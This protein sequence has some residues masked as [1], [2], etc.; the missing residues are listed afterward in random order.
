MAKPHPHKKR[1]KKKRDKTHNETKDSTFPHCPHTKWIHDRQWSAKFVHVICSVGVY[2]FFQRCFLR[3]V[4]GWQLAD[5]HAAKMHR[6]NDTLNRNDGRGASR[7]ALNKRTENSAKSL[8]NL[9]IPT[10]WQSKAVSSI[11]I[12]AKIS[13]LMINVEIFLFWDMWQLHHLVHGLAD[14]NKQKAKDIWHAE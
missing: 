1:K 10:P 7:L 13:H 2:F 11:C 9:L 6:L 12:P 14:P 8:I 3:L 4:Q 5:V